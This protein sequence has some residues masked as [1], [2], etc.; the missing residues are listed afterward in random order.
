MSMR[1]R[2]PVN[3]ASAL[4]PFRWRNR[5]LRK[6]ANGAQLRERYM[7]DQPQATIKQYEQ[8]SLE[9]WSCNDGE[10]RITADGQPSVFDII[11]VLGGQK[12]PRCVWDRLLRLFPDGC[13]SVVQHQFPGQGQ[14][15]TP[16]LVCANDAGRLLDLLGPRAERRA[17]K[18]G[19]AQPITESAMRK[20]I[21]AWFDE[22]EENPIEHYPCAT[23]IVDIKTDR[24]AVE[25]KEA[26]LWKAAVGQAIV[27]ADCLGLVPEIALF[28]D[29]DYQPV[30]ETCTK[31]GVA[32]TTYPITDGCARYMIEGTGCYRETNYET[33]G[34]IY[35][36]RSIAK[37]N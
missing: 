21:A 22:C 13:P 19:V 36:Q 10:I 35:K 16:V 6:T 3:P 8:L 30:L 18:A 28:G 11:K 37:Y 32:C 26:S 23:G 20:A 34:G 12:N 33:L 17:R 31:L 4:H 27:Y 7:T 2:G 15:L 24:T 25:V 9:L 29:Y 1:K 14:R 5:L